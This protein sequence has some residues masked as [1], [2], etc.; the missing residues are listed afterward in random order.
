MAYKKRDQMPLQLKIITNRVYAILFETPIEEIKYLRQLQELD[1]LV[2]GYY[3]SSGYAYSMLFQFEKAIP[4]YE[5]AL[6]I[7]DKSGIKPAWVFNYTQLGEAYN[8]TG[9]YK[10]EK[11]LYIKAEKDF[12]DNL[13]LDYQKCLLATV[14]GDTVNAKK[15]LEKGIRMAKENSWTEANIAA[16]MAFG[17]S[18]VGKK[19]KA[20]KYYRK[21]LSLEPDEPGRMNDL[22]FLLI[23]S[24]RNITEGI[25]L[26]DKALELKPDNYLFLHTKGW[27]LYK[28]GKY[29]EALDMLQKSWDLRR[30]KAVY[31]HQAYLHLEAA[32][33]VVAGLKK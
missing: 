29:R 7:Y 32:K 13:N 3:Y 27:G 8:K 11:K 6:E 14:E 5:K 4:E 31:D 19:D 1:D 15:Y 10:K 18:D 26:V 9:Q 22:A 23:D 12:P 21:A 20:E 16:Q 24:E 25:D 2:P 17:F 33:K 30:E 28:Q